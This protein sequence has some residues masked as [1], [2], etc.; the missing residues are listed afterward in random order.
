MIYASYTLLLFA[1]ALLIGLVASM[2]GVGGGSLFV[3]FG[4]LIFPFNIDFIRG[5]GIVLAVVSAAS[6]AP[7]LVKEGFAN[8]RI[9]ISIVP[10]MVVTSVIGSFVGL[11]ITDVLPKGSSIVRTML[12]LVI[13]LVFAVMI[14][15]KRVEHPEVKRVD[16]ISRKLGLGGYYYSGDSI[17]E[18][19]ITNF[20]VGALIF[21]LIGFMAGMFGLGAGW[22]NVPVLNLVMGAPIKVAVATSRLIITANAAAIGVYVAKGAVLPVIVVPSVL[23]VMIGAKIGTELS[24]IVKPTVLKYFVLFVLFLA[25]ILNVIKGVQGLGYLPKIIP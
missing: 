13:L 6:T 24:R 8:V 21:G 25:G 12:G 18:Y 7:S 4:A 3:A 14:L 19:K 22:A 20:P 9:F 23:G 17:V 1:F 2:S 11:W 15:S 16:P 10:V 5:A